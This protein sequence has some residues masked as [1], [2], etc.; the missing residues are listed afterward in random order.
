VELQ[1][2]Y[3]M[4]G[5]LIVSVSTMCCIGAL[6]HS[7]PTAESTSMEHQIWLYIDPTSQP[8]K[9]FHLSWFLCICHTTV[10]ARA[11]S[12]CAVCPSVRL[13]DRTDLVTTISHEWLEQSWWSLQF[14]YR[15]YLPPHTD[16]YIHTY[17][18]VFCIAHINSVESLCASVAKQ[19]RLFESVKWQSRPS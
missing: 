17:V 10:S 6:W 4:F 5:C 9:C 16:T 19:V 15:E 18:R 14:F 7:Y 8:G 12:C 11:F 3:C 1:L 2:N 13:I